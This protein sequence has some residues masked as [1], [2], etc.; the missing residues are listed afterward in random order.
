MSSLKC[1]LN[2]L[3]Y[4]LVRYVIYMPQVHNDGFSKI[5]VSLL[6]PPSSLS[7]PLYS[8]FIIENLI[9]QNYKLVLFFCLYVIQT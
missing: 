6:L 8:V 3:T 5:H 4:S 1:V 2:R 7:S 9:A